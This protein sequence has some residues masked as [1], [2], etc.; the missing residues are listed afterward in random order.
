MVTTVSIIVAVMALSF[1]VFQMIRNLRAAQGYGFKVKRMIWMLCL[2]AIVFSLGALG[3]GGNPCR[4]LMESTT[5]MQSLYMLAFCL[6]PEREDAG[7]YR[8]FPGLLI[9]M[10]VYY[11]V[12]LTGI[13]PMPSDMLCVAVADVVVLLGMSVFIRKVY[14]RL[15][16]VKVVM[17][18]GNSWSFLTICSDAVYMLVPAGILLLM[19]A[20]SGVFPAGSVTFVLVAV[21]LVHLEMIMVCVRVSYDSAFAIMHD[22]ER[23]I[24][25]SMKLSQA[26]VTV[27]PDSRRESQ[28]KD[29]YERISHYFE[30]SKP[31]LDG[32]LTINDVVKVVYSNKVYISK[33]ICH[34]TGRNFRQFVNYHRV[35]YSMALFRENLELKVSD[36]AEHSGFN[37]MVS[38]TMAFR[39][40]MDETPSDWCR[41]ERSRILKPKK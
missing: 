37:N 30:V 29:L 19:H 25:E 2:A 35:M 38:Y 20:L 21:V 18:S 34:Y 31:Y 36:L 1:A 3:G 39:L 33:A 13:A 40:F 10:L 28:Y 12:C 27:S 23:I 14:L 8:I 11:V 7:V 5:A 41:K 4:L 24:V 15:R 17:K 22:H 16:D 26:D 9:L 6:N 32:N